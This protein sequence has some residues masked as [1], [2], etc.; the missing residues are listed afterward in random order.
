MVFFGVTQ[1]VNRFSEPDSRCHSFSLSFSAF[2]F[3]QLCP[4]NWLWGRS[5]IRVAEVAQLT[6]ILP[7]AVRSFFKT[8][9]LFH[10]HG[11]KPECMWGTCVCFSWETIQQSSSKTTFRF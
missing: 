2:P 4:W 5:L 1:T 8:C 3:S 9:P 7:E 10:L 11:S 6:V